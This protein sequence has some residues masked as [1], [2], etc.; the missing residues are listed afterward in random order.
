LN[1]EI[2]PGGSE[3]NIYIFSIVSLVI[4]ILAAVNFVNL[5]TAR[6][7]RRAKE[8]GIRKT[9]GNLRIK[10]ISQFLLESLLTSGIAMMFAIILA[11]VFLRVFELI[12]GTKLLDTIWRNPSTV[13]I[14]FVFAFVVGILS[15]IYPAFYL[16]SFIPAKVLKGNFS[17]AGKGF[18]NFLVVF[19]FTVSIL[20]ITCAIV[21]QSQLRFISNK[22]LGFDQNNVVTIDRID[23]L[24]KNAEVFKNKLENQKGVVRSSFHTGEPGSK[25]IMSFYTFQTQEM[26][27]PVSIS[28]YLG[29]D[30]FIALNS[31]RLV[32]GRNFNK[33]L[34]SDSLSIIL[35]EAAVKAL[36]LGNDPIGATINN[37]QH[38]IGVVSDFHWESLRNTI[39]PV[40]ILIGKDNAELSFK[41][42]AGAASSFL[43]VAESGWKELALDEPF[44][45]HFLDSNFGEL[46]QKEAVFGKAVNFFTLL[47]IF[48]SC[49]GLYGLSAFTAEQRT[50]EIGIRKVMGA[51]SSAIVLMLNRQFAVLVGIALAISIPLSVYITQQW[52]NDF[53][54]RI[55]LDFWIFLLAAV[56]SGI[57]AL[58]TVSYHSVKAAWANPTDS[59]KYE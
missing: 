18:R 41:I 23:L 13:G 38:V 28:T 48:I 24:K 33:D 6:A 58:I 59:L 32:K 46:L 53:A 22:D 21:V 9:M 14:F 19:Q 45:Y 12:T 50:K 44:R 17:I 34:A 55:Q 57:V 30:E 10:L 8:V 5:T 40:A 52:L 15:G 47:A 56:S 1:F 27:H 51:S 25:R 37:K 42:E 16:T 4:L 43:K 54:Y 36:D 39:A 2:S 31:M 11:E 3:S 35:N 49:L 29:D 26:D 20:L 7:S